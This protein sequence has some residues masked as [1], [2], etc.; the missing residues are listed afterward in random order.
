MIRNLTKA[1][2]AIATL[3][4]AECHRDKAYIQAHY[5]SLGWTRAHWE[6]TADTVP[7]T[8]ARWWGQLTGVEQKAA[9]GLCFFET[10][11]D[12]VDMSPN[13]GYFP[14]P[15]PNFRYKPWSELHHLTHEVAR[16]KLGYT[17][18]KWDNLGTSVVERNTFLNLSPLER[19]GAMDLGFYMHT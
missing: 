7:Y 17:E 2:I 3:A 10:N 5:R 8:E 6:R 4:I 12:K 13:P 16:D 18:E 14:H 1:L 9:N 19:E 11:W 15:M